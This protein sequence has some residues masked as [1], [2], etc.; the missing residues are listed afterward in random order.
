MA[1]KSRTSHLAVRKARI[2][3]TASTKNHRFEPFS[4]RIAKL[5][6]DPLRRVRE[7]Q[8]ETNDGATSSY[9]RSALD[10]WADRNLSED[11]SEFAKQVLS[12]SDSLP[13]IIH[14]EQKITDLLLDY[15]EKGKTVALEPLLD[16]VAHLAHDLGLRFEKHFAR[17]LSTVSNLAAKHEDVEVIEWSFNCLA[18]LFKYLSRLLV[19]DLR[20]VYDLMAPLLG[21]ERQKPFVARFAAE[22][23]S[24]LL[25]KAASHAHKDG[26]PLHL[27]VEHIERDVCTAATGKSDLYEQGVAV[28]FVE[29]IQGSQQALHSGGAV[30]FYE[31]LSITFESFDKEAEP[32]A[33]L[34]RL[35]QV[36]LMALLQRIDGASL[37]PIVE[38][39]L[40]KS[41]HIKL[42]AMHPS[43][44][45]LYSG[46]LFSII[47]VKSGS[48]VTTWSP[49]LEKIITLLLGMS[50]E[51]DAKVELLKV[52]AVA[53]QNCPLKDAISHV[54]F[55]ETL[56]SD[57]QWR[58][59]FLGFCMFYGELGKERFKDML[60][61]HFKRF[62]IS[63]WKDYK[64]QICLALPK[65]TSA[66]W[67]EKET[68]KLPAQ[69][70]REIAD[71]F[72]V[73]QVSDETAEMVHYKNGLLELLM[74]AKVS[75]ESENRILSGLEFDIQ[76]ALKNSHAGSLRPL[77]VF[78]AG[79]ALLYFTNH[80]RNW[81]INISRSLLS[82]AKV[83]KCF[84]VFWQ[85]LLNYIES[86]HQQSSFDWSEEGPLMALLDCL[87]CPDH[88]MRLVAL[89]IL[90]CLHS[91]E[92]GQPS[93][94]MQLAISIARTVPSVESIRV[95][96]MQLRNLAKAYSE[97]E[98][99]SFLIRAIPH[100]CF[101][102]LHVRLAPIWDSTCDA[103]KE[104]CER[105]EGEEI[106]C[107]IAFHW[108]E[109]VDDVQIQDH[110]T[111][112]QEE[113][114]GCLKESPLYEVEKIQ[115]QAENSFSYFEFPKRQ[116]KAIFEKTHTPA[117]SMTISN[118]TQALKV[119]KSVP[120]SA[121]KKSR[122]LVPVLLNWALDVDADDALIPAGNTQQ[123]TVDV[124]KSQR[125]GRKDQ[126]AMLSLFSLFKNP[127]ALYKTSEVY[128]AMLALLSHGDREIQRY[129][130]E[131]ILTWKNPTISRYEEQLKGFLEDA[132]FKEQLTIFLDI[133]SDDDSLQDS[134]R[135]EIL[136][137]VFRLMYGRII[138]KGKGDQQA[139]RKAVF[140]II[141]RFEDDEVKQF[142]EVLLGRLN[143]LELVKK[144]V[145][146]EQNLTEELLDQRRQL[147]LINMLHDFL[148]TLRMTAASFTP[149][150]VD[151]VIYCLIRAARNSIESTNN[152]ESDEA[153]KFGLARSIRQISLRCL[154]LIFDIIPNFAWHLYLPVL[155]NDLIRP[156]LDK[157]A[158]EN[159]Q[160]VSGFLRLFSAWAKHIETVSFLFRF[161]RQLVSRLAECVS[162]HSTKEEVRRFVL[163]E[164]FGNVLD[165]AQEGD[166]SSEAWSLL[167][168]HAPI[169][170]QHLGTA[171]T[172][173]S[174]KDFLDDGV[175]L[176][177]RLA[178]VVS[179]TS[180]DLLSSLPYLLVQSS[181][182]VSLSAKT[183]A[184]RIILRA[185]PV[186]S[187]NDELF[188][189]LYDSICSSFAYFSDRES[190]LL[191]CD[192]LQELARKKP[193]LKTP[194]NLCSDLN[195]FAA[196]RLDEPDYDRRTG[197]FSLLN[198]QIH[199][200]LE[201]YQWQPLIYNMLFF[202]KNTEELAIRASATQSLRRFIDAA[203]HR[204]MGKDKA[205]SS[206]GT[207]DEMPASNNHDFLAMLERVVLSSIERGIRDQPEL[208]R[209]EYLSVISYAVSQLPGWPPLTGLS[210]LLEPDDEN[211]FFNNILHIQQHRR[212]RALKRLSEEVSAGHVGSK[213]L[214][215]FIIPLIERF[216]LDDEKRRETAGEVTGEAV[217]TIGSCLEG[218]DWNQYRS[219]MRRY[220][221]DVKRKGDVREVTLK[222]VDG[223]ASTLSMC[224]QLKYQHDG[225]VVMSNH[226]TSSTPRS[227]N[228]PR[229]Q[230]T[231]PTQEKL[232]LYL[233]EDVL[234]SL[235]AFLRKK[236]DEVVSLRSMVAVTIARLLA[237]LP[238][239]DFQ[240]RL[241]AVLLDTC[242]IL[243]S[244]DPVSRD[245]A[246][247]ALATMCQIV[248]PQSISFV[249]KA[250]RSAL[251]HGFHLHVLSFTVHSILTTTTQHFKSGSLDYCLPE[252]VTVI[253][254]DI[255]GNTGQEKDE[256]EYLKDK[257]SKKEVKQR[258][259]FDT[260]QLLASI[261]SL[262][263]LIELIRPLEL[264]LLEDLT[265]KMLRDI[266]ELLRRIDLGLMQNTAVKDRD[267]LIFCHELIT[268]A[269]RIA[270]QSTSSEQKKAS[271]Y[272][273]RKVQHVAHQKLTREARIGKVVRFGLEL[274][275][276]VFRK[277]KDLA[278]AANIEG[279]LPIIG[280]AVLDEQEDVKLAAF[281]LFTQIVTVPIARIEFEAPVYVAEAVKVIENSEGMEREELPAAALKL[282]AAVLREKRAVQVKDRVVALL[283]KQ[284]KPDLQVKNQQ[285]S[286]FTLLKAIVIRKIVIPEVYELMDGD[287]GVGAISI[288]DHDRTT[289][290]LARSVWFHFL[291]DYPQGKGRFKK[292]L[293]F[294]AANLNFEHS[295][296]RKAVMETLFLMI[297]KYGPEQL[298]EVISVAD[299]S[300]VAV[301]VN[302]EDQ[303]CREMAS[304]LVKTI[305]KKADDTWLSAFLVKLR[306]MLEHGNKPILQRTALQCWALCIE[307]EQCQNSDIHFVLRELEGILTANNDSGDEEEQWDLIFH[308]LHTFRVICEHFTQVAFSEISSSIWKSA[309]LRLSFPH[310]WVKHESALLTGLFFQ[311]FVKKG[312][313]TVPLIAD[314]LSLNQVELCELAHRHLRLLTDR[315]N[316]QAANQVAENLSLI[317]VWFAASQVPWTQQSIPHSKAQ[318]DRSSGEDE[319]EAEE[320]DSEHETKPALRHL[321]ERLS[322]VLRRQAS[323]SEG[324]SISHR[325]ADLLIAKH[326]AINILTKLVDALP[327]DVLSANMETLLLPLI[328]LTDVDVPA[329][330]HDRAYTEGMQ[331]LTD[332]A[333]ELLDKLQKKLGTT[334]YV[335]ALQKV[336]K[337]IQ[338]RREERRIKRKIEVVS[339]PERA[340]R[341]K[342]K[343]QEAR[344]VRRKEKS[345]FA[346]GQRR[347]W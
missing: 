74:V 169:I 1:G 342:R 70:Q 293:A 236:E 58:P 112:E 302:D 31:M 248:G 10:E 163:N 34:T 251:Q 196:N 275:R 183:D 333:T 63:H 104:M 263:H 171:L 205:S 227:L 111:I 188:D 321:L 290:D 221:G 274:L 245:A 73:R 18:W 3:T 91:Q 43:Y 159:A 239:V 340:E 164:I 192:I 95:I 316:K 126:K 276:A 294:L 325:R 168:E 53:H 247:K 231:L 60:L 179:P 11:F 97:V 331:A 155:F 57:I 308:G 336:K 315:S 89:E 12:I 135:S 45:K 228:P 48:K 273:I 200:R 326:A 298:R 335:T 30:L 317:G 338:E 320:L 235:E 307:N 56:A 21:K 234:P 281:R 80:G 233:L 28:L 137:L 312:L 180:T 90:D 103:L 211:S 303:E 279:F 182:K 140:T 146:H 61:P 67:L 297:T 139:D 178:D 266:D 190:R 29:S 7:R 82:A 9:F 40:K 202:I 285:G 255:F 54:K 141:S 186:A 219:V 131:A 173:E 218:L 259:S 17:V 292:Q 311:H 213:N 269:N 237:I 309:M 78:S 258:T 318:D 282:V 22:S 267:I 42:A 240:T 19:P 99:D 246:R 323:R 223:A 176:I 224:A 6:I 109:G 116:L 207:E 347:G 16:L 94:I 72:S 88:F 319:V 271:R 215:H 252:I 313:R 64:E 13:Q 152:I 41:Q 66:G 254:D 172:I 93:D 127:K 101:G 35:L 150:L 344:K 201:C 124:D 257:A 76:R 283:L 198:E 287:E 289:R 217:R 128:S 210:T 175:K 295:E 166:K 334:M 149:Q 158:Q 230:Q 209:A 46:L 142:L 96:T 86:S 154:I 79:N 296:G 110:Q 304:T 68:L 291:M 75:D 108:L 23:M 129:A 122:L 343:K 194:A 256:Q 232:S 145:F 143:Q 36:V 184:L 253:M 39:I 32:P 208:I 85:A 328:H 161:D 203:A 327:A 337:G 174:T 49:V 332:S 44:L 225:D 265:Q 84:Q 199:S 226:E 134:H 277:H 33:P 123:S 189:Q 55:L 62:F 92:K 346:R 299:W 260:M 132:K 222:L 98:P 69:W 300:L 2:P 51:R 77:D 206:G 27:I 216:V 278:T 330:P 214:A 264:L 272:L 306:R 220:I 120:Q 118:R 157:L 105:K 59:H 121:E 37:K 5:K 249:L 204:S 345:S 341:Q 165:L 286:A 50:T 238:H 241:P 280:D 339:L 314:G 250:L 107:D 301:M 288:R 170:L 144:G 71:G 212:I 83:F 24:F 156:R 38:I 261:T 117:K 185:T 153:G 65:F 177:V 229:L 147:G 187:I 244:K 114:K 305:I 14:H 284:L 197:A 310:S 268:D 133:G 167:S 162:N 106:I 243:R 195:S 322:K 52:F 87:S 181:K 8:I 160:A 25:R 115:E 138:T 262:T 151:P 193:A 113:K 191:L 242:N 329:V 324:E 26:R 4:Q 81:N 15:I 130:L 100:L 102:L 125:W 148:D 270:K 119:L 47:G 136:P 20:P